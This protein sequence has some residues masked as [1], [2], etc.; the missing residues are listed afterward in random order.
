M[1]KFAVKYE[2]NFEEKLKLVYAKLVEAGVGFR[3]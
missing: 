1:E 3:V 2:M